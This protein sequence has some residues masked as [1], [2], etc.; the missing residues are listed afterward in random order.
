MDPSEHENSRKKADRTFFLILLPFF[1]YL[2]YCIG[3]FPVR[4]VTLDNLSDGVLDVLLH[5][6]PFAVS[7]WTIKTI[8]AS[9]LIWFA[10]FLKAAGHDGNFMPGK[11]FG[12]ARFADIGEVNEELADPDDSMN[13]ILSQH[14]R[15]SLDT[16]RT[17]LNNNV[18]VIGGSGAG[19]SFYFVQPNGLLCNTSMIFTD[20]K[21][22]LLHRLGGILELHGYRVISFNLIDP[23]KSDGYNPFD[24][25]RSDNDIIKL[26]TNIMSN[27][28]PKGQNGGDPFWDNALS[29]YLQ[30]V[31]SYV[32]YE[33]PKQGKKATIREMLNLLNLAKVSDDETK[34]SGLDRLME[35]L[36]DDHPAKVAY[37]KVVSGAADTVRSI[38]ISA[39]ARLAFLQN[40]K[41]LNIL[42]HDDMDIR[43]IGEGVYENP[44]RK[45]ALFCVIPDND[46]SYNFLVG[47]LYSQIFQELYYIADFK[48]GGSLP[49]HTAFWMDEFANVALPDDF[50]K[51]ISTMRSRN[52]SCN[53]ILQ[54]KAQLQALFK[55]EWQ[56]II[57][58][59][60]TMIYLGGNE[61]ETHKYMTEMLGKFTINK[62][63]EG[64]SLGKNGSSS[65]NYDV[66][67]RE[68]MTPDEVRRM[69]K[70][71]CLVFIR[72]CN[73]IID[74]KYDTLH[75]EG[76]K[77]M[78]ALGEYK[79]HKDWE[80][81]EDQGSFHFYLE[82][83][84]TGGKTDS[85]HYQIENYHG[86]FAESSCFDSLA[87]C[88]QQPGILVGTEKLGAYRRKSQNDDGSI[89][90]SDVLPAFDMVHPVTV[91]AGGGIMRKYPLIGYLDDGSLV[92]MTE[93][94]CE[95][96]FRKGNRSFTR[97][98]AS[99]PYGRQVP[100]GQKAKKTE[101]ESSNA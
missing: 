22:E 63:S 12:T 32:W 18:V 5:P 33:S 98:P 91:N 28:K 48:Y 66:L 51:I 95:D 35:V 83:Q 27:T 11:E 58:N 81:L 24:Y 9:L 2:G 64:E 96:F 76:F 16:H 3:L 77:V 47:V 60:D 86:V 45:T 15:V 99:G 82:G 37:K 90:E 17:G 59:A 7:D 61:A 97:K 55:D 23:D 57:G 52:I 75:C 38:I 4:H 34:K 20:P 29:L 49:I 84:G 101:E 54:N 56:S 68:L 69:D 88:P 93:A 92:E 1:V 26:V 85:Y 94:E 73:P 89:Q 74:D 80:Q 43:A 25:I 19:K 65:H 67:G 14:V 8:A 41:I 6:F 31:M 21:G 10:L 62:Q 44:D 87:K 78:N 100:Q 30:A 46:K 39:H 70:R 53:I 71:K 36:P 72:G 40:P 50:T 42:D 79:G 13:K